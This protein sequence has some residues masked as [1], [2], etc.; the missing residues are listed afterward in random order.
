[1]NNGSATGG[2]IVI[3]LL[4]FLAMGIVSQSLTA[5][6]G[7]VNVSGNAFLN[8]SPDHSGILVV[9]E[10]VSPSAVSDSAVTETGGHF[11]ILL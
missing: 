4:V 3:V 9:F 10:A 6:Q 1:M 7:A 5:P 11:D 8:D 2:R